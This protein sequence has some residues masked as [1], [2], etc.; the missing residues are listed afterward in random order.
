MP[1]VQGDLRDRVSPASPICRLKIPV[2]GVNHWVLTKFPQD[3]EWSPG[4][5]GTYKGVKGLC[6][7]TS[8]R[9]AELNVECLTLQDFSES[10]IC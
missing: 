1:W 2:G 4:F 3:I 9:N 6:A 5:A 8:L 10:L 7:Q